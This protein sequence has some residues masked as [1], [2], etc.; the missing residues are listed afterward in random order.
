MTKPPTLSVSGNSP[1]AARWTATYTRTR[2]ADGTV[3]STQRQAVDAVCEAARRNTRILP[4]PPAFEIRTC[5]LSSCRNGGKASGRQD[6]SA[7]F[8]IELRHYARV[9]PRSVEL[10]SVAAVPTTDDQ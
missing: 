2:A 7:A 4:D 5:R 8:R 9:A 10:R 1:R 3:T 6:E